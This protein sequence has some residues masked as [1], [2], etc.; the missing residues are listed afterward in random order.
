ML[1]VTLANAKKH[2]AMDHS[3]DDDLITLYIHGASAIVLNYLKIDGTDYE[4]SSGLSYDLIPYEVQTATLLMIAHL[5]EN[6]GG[7]K[8]E[9]YQQGSLPADVTAQLYPLR[10]PTL[11]G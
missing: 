8:V 2:L 9:N 10:D 11:N 6:R 4:D 7:E 1:L 5:Y 3:E